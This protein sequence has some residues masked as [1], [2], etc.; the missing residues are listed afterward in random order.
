[1]GYTDVTAGLESTEGLPTYSCAAVLVL[2]PNIPI[3]FPQLN[4][5]IIK[6]KH[7]DLDFGLVE[8]EY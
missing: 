2:H 3:L 5:I 8:A 1:M 4:F 6:T 7:M